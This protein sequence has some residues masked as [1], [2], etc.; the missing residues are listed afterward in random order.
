MGFPTQ[1]RYFLFIALGS[2]T[3]AALLIY[4]LVYNY[5]LIQPHLTP[6][7]WSLCSALVLRQVKKPVINFLEWIQSSWLKK[8]LKG[9]IFLYYFYCVMEFAINWDSYQLG[10][11][12][13]YIVLYI[14]LFLLILLPIV[15]ETE[16]FATLI[17]II[18][19]LILGL[20]GI[21]II[22]KTCYQESII[23]TELIRSFIENNKDV[24]L[25]FARSQE[26]DAQNVG[27]MSPNPMAINPFQLNVAESKRDIKEFLSLKTSKDI[28]SSAENL[29]EFV[30]TIALQNYRYIRSIQEMFLMSSDDG[31]YAL[32]REALEKM[33]HDTCSSNVQYLRDNVYN[34]MIQ[35]ANIL[36]SNIGFFGS[37]ITNFFKTS[38]DLLNG[39]SE[40]I[41][42]IFIYFTFLFYFVK[43]SIC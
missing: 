5:F 8:I 17:V 28:W 37:T 4:V 30:A 34:L 21:F 1:Y 25:N 36:G 14:I 16:T 18:G 27:D 3:I 29:C 6:I 22:V 26:I 42:S 12:F 33:V 20:L 19:V 9:F 39:L 41:F 31:S 7:F 43:V 11:R 24:I 35:T 40:F 32:E 15:L 2:L 10:E 23:A 38:L 13:L